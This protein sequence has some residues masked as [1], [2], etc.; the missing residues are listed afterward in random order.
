MNVLPLNNSCHVSERR[1]PFKDSPPVQKTKFLI[2]LVY[3]MGMIRRFPGCA[4]R[5]AKSVLTQI[6]A[7]TLRPSLWCLLAVPEHTKDRLATFPT[8]CMLRAI[9]GVL[10]LLPFFPL[11]LNA[12]PSSRGFETQ[13]FKTLDLIRSGFGHIRG[14]PLISWSPNFL[15]Q[16]MGI[17]TGVTLFAYCVD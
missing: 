13:W 4:E 10:S 7:Q 6:T 14:N 16:K 15:L 2:F 11:Y 8:M 12:S 1:Q 5:W 17:I 3:G 9:P